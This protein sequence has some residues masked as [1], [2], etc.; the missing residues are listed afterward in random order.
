MIV[1]INIVY[2]LRIEIQLCVIVIYLDR[3]TDMH[4][5]II[6]FSCNIVS[7][8]FFSNI[9]TDNKNNKKTDSY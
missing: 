8:T 2:A 1:Y 3:L 7:I 9:K 5:L 4:C 6:F